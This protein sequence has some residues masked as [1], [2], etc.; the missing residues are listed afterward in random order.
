MRADQL[1]TA[2]DVANGV[3]GLAIVLPALA[4]VLF[5]L[6]VYLARG[7]RRRTSRTTGWCLVLIGV[8][9]LLIRRLAGDAVV[10][11]LVKIASN[12]P[13]V[14]DVWNIATV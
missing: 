7:R 3:K 6:A 9:L 8:V 11:G 1:R 12:K 13:A 4:I 2:Q 14:H 10:D 5:A